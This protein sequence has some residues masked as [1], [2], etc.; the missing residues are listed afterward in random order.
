MEI[1][2][3]L[4]SVFTIISFVTFIGIVQWAW[5][6]RRHDA[7]VAAAHAPFALP[8]ESSAE[9]VAEDGAHR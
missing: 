7:F 8:E 5:S 9:P 1:Y 6:A 2:S 3:A 4:S